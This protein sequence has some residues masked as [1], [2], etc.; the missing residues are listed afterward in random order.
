MRGTMPLMIRPAEPPDIP[1]MAEIRAQTKGTQSFW[2]DRIDRYLRG[3]HSPQQALPL[4]SAF[5]AE[6]QGKIVGFVAGHRTRRFD[7]DGEVQWIDVDQ[8][9]RGRGIGYKLL[10][11]MGS[12]FVSQE[13]KRI[14]VN[15]D[16]NNLAARKL[17]ETCGARP[18]SEAW[19][20]WDDSSLICK[21]ADR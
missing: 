9:H 8:Q 13:T 1:S 14:C 12:W 20:V 18:L 17:Y 7:C 5:V 21:L 2:A 6:D 15:V 4:R 3:E 10:A 11:Q 16:T 19:M